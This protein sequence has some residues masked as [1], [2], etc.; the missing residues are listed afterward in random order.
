M[1]F[2]RGCPKIKK[3]PNWVSPPVQAQE[4]LTLHKD[5]IRKLV[6]GTL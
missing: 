4:Q 3:E 6:H 2:H 5:G 1:K